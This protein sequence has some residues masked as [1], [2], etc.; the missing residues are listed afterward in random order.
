MN[1]ATA[2]VETYRQKM[3][4]VC[5]SYQRDVSLSE[6]STR[7]LFSF[8]QRGGWIGFFIL[9]CASIS[10]AQY[11]HPNQAGRK[12]GD[13]G[14][15]IGGQVVTSTYYG[16]AGNILAQG[17][18]MSVNKDGT[19]PAAFHDFDGYPGDGSYP[20]Y[21]TPH[22][23]SN[24]KLY[25]STLYGGTSNWGAVYDYDFSTCSENVIFNNGQTPGATAPSG[26]ILNYCNIN[27][28]SDGKIYSVQTY[29]GAYALGGIFRMD[30]D[31]SNVQIVHSFSYNLDA[32][33]ITSGTQLVNYT[34]AANAQVVAP[35]DKYDGAYPYAFVVEGAD[36]KLYGT[37]YYGGA[38]N[39]GALYRCDKDGSNYEI[40]NIGDPTLRATYKDGSNNIIPLSYNAVFSFG[41]VAI[42]A[43]GKVYMVS[44]F[45]GVNNIGAIARMDADGGNYQILQSGSG[46][47][48]YYPLRGPV[49]IDNKLYGTY[50]EATG[51]YGIVWSMN[52]DG[53]GTNQ[54]YKFPASLAEGAHPWAGLSY[55]GI[56][57]FGTSIEGGGAGKIGTIFKIKPDGT[58][59]TTIHRFSDTQAASNC[60]GTKKGLWTYYP[61]AERVT[62]AN[63]NLNCNKACATNTATCT[64]SNTPPTL[65]GTT[66]SNI[67]LSTTAN[68]TTLTSGSGI[69]WHTATPATYGNRVSDPTTVTAG[70]YYATFYDVTND[71]YSTSASA[72]V[73]VTI[74]PCSNVLAL[75]PGSLSKSLTTTQDVAK[76]GNIATVASPQGQAPFTYTAVDC[77]S[78]TV[79]GTTAK[80]GTFTVNAT[81]GAY[82]YTPAAGYTGI[83]AFC[84]KI[85]D[86]NSPTQNCKTLNC[87]VTV[88]PKSCDAR[89]TAPN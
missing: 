14:V 75:A 65:L 56:H 50:W 70:T 36:G 82:T 19:N 89:G 4:S 47:N 57:L 76:T 44:K 40:I 73:T 86:G 72:A 33:P 81:T 62:F 25:G 22:Q 60:G 74:N 20:F 39:Y 10:M 66:L 1:T 88:A 30:K 35:Y 2:I 79:S 64:A 11:V 77:S 68:L 41:N 37:T 59:F 28:M 12:G 24:G 26:G 7:F 80:G 38:Y 84:V 42:D 5:R 53:T 63:V 31:G 43:A 85:C 32:D 61:S 46:A 27:E 13:T 55:D 17:V 34:T 23:A 58:D 3:I 16:N 67:C 78:G 45:G 6:S 49:I 8:L 18:I 83:D 87:S 52:L 15:G 69:T 9:G 71:C 51:F 54:M 48:G 21:T 29:G